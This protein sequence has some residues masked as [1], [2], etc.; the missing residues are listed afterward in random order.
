MMIVLSEPME[1]WDHPRA[2][3]GHRDDQSEG[4]AWPRLVTTV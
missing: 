2:V 4:H 1:P 3:E